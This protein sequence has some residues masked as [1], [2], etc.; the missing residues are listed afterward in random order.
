LSTDVNTKT[1]RIF[2]DFADSRFRIRSNA[3]STIF[4]TLNTNGTLN[5]SIVIK[6]TAITVN[7]NFSNDSS[8]NLSN[9]PGKSTVSNRNF[10]YTPGAGINKVLISTNQQG[11]VEW[12]NL[13][14]VF[15]TFPIGSIISIRA[16]E[17]SSTNFWLDGQVTTTQGSPLYNIYGRGKLGSD[18]EGWYLC[19]GQTWEDPNSIDETLTPNLNNFSYTIDPNS[20]G[21]PQIT[22]ADSEAILIGG[23]DLKIQATTDIDG[24]YSVNYTNSFT[25]NNA[26]LGSSNINMNVGSGTHYTSRMIHIVFLENPNLVWIAT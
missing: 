26:S 17:F 14:D 18:F 22:L 7:D 21:Q 5:D 25:D 24:L 12:K 19:N 11:D 1:L 3:S 20:N 10:R 9:T 8:F 16:N 15:G 23:Y 13:K 2:P 4:K 6:N